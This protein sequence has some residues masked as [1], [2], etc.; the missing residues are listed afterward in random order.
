MH[1]NDAI[2]EDVFSAYP[3]LRFD[4]RLPRLWFHRFQAVYMWATF[5]LLTLVFSV[6]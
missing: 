3:F 1:C 5:P 4:A 6:R 2:D